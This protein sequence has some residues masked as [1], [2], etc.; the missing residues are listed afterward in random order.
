[1]QFCFRSFNQKIDQL[2]SLKISSQELL[3]ACEQLAHTETHY[4]L[5]NALFA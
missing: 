1:M 3:K 4:G 5:A 2:W